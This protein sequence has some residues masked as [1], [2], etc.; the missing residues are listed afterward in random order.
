MQIDPCTYGNLTFVPQRFLG[1]ACEVEQIFSRLRNAEFGSSAVVG[2]WQ[3]GKKP[4]LNY[5]V[6]SGVCGSHGLGLV[7]YSFL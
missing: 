6:K 1:R 4:L 3:I 2:G 5:L 7:L